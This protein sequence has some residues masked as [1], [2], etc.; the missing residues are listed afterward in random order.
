[1]GPTLKQAND[2]DTDGLLDF[3]E[4]AW[5]SRPDA[6]DTDGDGAS[7]FEERAANTD[8]RSSASVPAPLVGAGLVGGFGPAAGNG[9]T[10]DDASEPPAEPESLTTP[11]QGPPE[12]I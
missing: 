5:G 8:A 7:D 10:P 9:P 3:Q 6:A 4:L 12:A 11:E 1:M 2:T